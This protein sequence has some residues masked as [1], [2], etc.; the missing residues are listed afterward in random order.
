MRTLSIGLALGLA[1]LAGQARAASMRMFSYDPA[2]AETRHASGGVT[3]QF[4]Q[5]LVFTRILALRSTMGQANALLEPVDEKVLGVGLSHLIGPNAPERD[6]YEVK[7]E[8]EGADLISAFCPGS[9]RGFM[10]FGRLR[11]NRPLRV[12]VLGDTP[13]GGPAHLCRTLDFTF[14]GEWQLPSA[15]P[16][17]DKE[18]KRPK[19]PY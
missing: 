14:H 4:R 7:P 5:Q 3:F 16:I 17:P 2:N 9:K 1:V 19:F 10:T 13:A 15:A 11:A 6:L 18:L 8:A 12:H